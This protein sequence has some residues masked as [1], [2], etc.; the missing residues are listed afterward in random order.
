MPI[1]I[2]ERELISDPK[3]RKYGQYRSYACNDFNVGS[4]WGY[5]ETQIEAD[6]N[7]I[8]KVIQNSVNASEYAWMDKGIRNRVVSV[9]KILLDSQQVTDREINAEIEFLLEVFSGQL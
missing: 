1:K 7:A 3:L 4:Q 6:N 2:T 9:L 5:G 8:K